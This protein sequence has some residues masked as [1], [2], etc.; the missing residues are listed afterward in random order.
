MLTG[1]ERQSC[2]GLRPNCASCF[3]PTQ[4]DSRAEVTDTEEALQQHVAVVVA[5][6]TAIQAQ[7]ARL[8]TLHTE[9]SAQADKV[10]RLGAEVL[11]VMT[12]RR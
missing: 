5:A 12:S 2:C 7:A 10:Q 4:V 1:C 3:P 8:E 11:E 9:M 6:G